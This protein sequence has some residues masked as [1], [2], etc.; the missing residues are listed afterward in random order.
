MNGN[1]Q[2]KKNIKVLSWNKSHAHMISR[3]DTLKHIIAVNKPQIVAIQEANIYKS[4]DINDFQ[5][6]GFD[7]ITDSLLEQ[8]G[9][10]RAIIYI[11]SNLRYTRRH[12]Y[13]AQNEPMIVLTF[14]FIN[15][16]RQWQI[17]S[18]TAR[19]PDTG[20]PASTLCRYTD[21]INKWISLIDEKETYI[22]G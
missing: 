16:Y 20:T 13:E 14:N 9:R 22:C 10:A 5:I 12:Q 4:E 17:M 19:I 8:V 3:L 6:K 2:G 11:D 18:E 15:H 21:V 1:I 7:L